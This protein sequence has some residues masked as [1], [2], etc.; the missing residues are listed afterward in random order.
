MVSVKIKVFMV[1]DNKMIYP[2]KCKYSYFRK[3]NPKQDKEYIKT[4]KGGFK[5][6]HSVWY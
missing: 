6:W 4:Q 2:K 3:N 5:N 1:E